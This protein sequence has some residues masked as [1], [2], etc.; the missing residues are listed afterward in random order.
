MH[1]YADI[2]FLQRQTLHVFGRHSAHPQ[3]F[4][5]LYLLPLV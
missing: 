2:Y 4:Q 5:K 1:Q 3:E